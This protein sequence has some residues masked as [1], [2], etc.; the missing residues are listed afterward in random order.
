MNLWFIRIGKA[1]AV[2]KNEGVFRGGK[3]IFVSLG[4]LFRR[5]GSGDILFIASGVG[6]S[7]RYRCHHIAEALSFH[8]FKV[9]VTTQD[10]PFLLRYAERFSVFVFHR[11]RWTPRVERFVDVLKNRKKTVL[12]D[13]DDLVFDEVLFKQTAAYGAMNALEKKQYER[14]IGIEFLESSFV[15]AI[16]TSTA[17]L[18]EKLRIFGKPIFVVPNRLSEEDV[19]K[20]EGIQKQESG[21]KNKEVSKSILCPVVIGYFSGSTGHDRDFATV[22]RVLAELLKAHSN[23]R[24]FVAGPL[25]LPKMLMHFEERITRVSYAPRAE[26]FKNLASVDI[27]IA[28]LEIGDPFCEAKSELKFFEAGIVGV[29][30]VA[31]ATV[32][33][34][35]AIIDGVDGYV[36]TSENEWREKLDR[37]ISDRELRKSMGANARETT[38]CRYTT[39]NASSDEYI[40]FL[41][42]KVSQP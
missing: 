3:R 11:T 15:A 4:S 33:F 35:E 6:D 10:N 36:A 13:T 32:T 31:S 30:T 25:T 29:P 12:F 41:K 27:N 39:R 17:F 26:H 37:L 14:G 42:S 1:I 28:P 2:L 40:A 21:M 9:S 16:S 38:L 19:R 22:A 7:A 23:V 5:V 20:A 8:S 34:C 18:A 24:L